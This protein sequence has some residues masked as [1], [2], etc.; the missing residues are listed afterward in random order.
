M[1]YVK[2]TVEFVEFVR[3]GRREGMLARGARHPEF[4]SFKGQLGKNWQ[5]HVAPE[6]EVEEKKTM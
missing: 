2:R 6:A 4:V 3:G 5:V 1:M